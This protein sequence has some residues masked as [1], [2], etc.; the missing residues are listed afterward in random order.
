[1]NVICCFIQSTEFYEWQLTM[2]TLEYLLLQSALAGLCQLRLNANGA[3]AD[4][5]SREI[6]K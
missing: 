5:Y 1:M 3:A 2:H 6:G 4:F